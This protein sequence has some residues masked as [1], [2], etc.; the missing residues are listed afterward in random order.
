MCRIAVFPMQTI[1]SLVR[2]LRPGLCLRLWWRR[3]PVVGASSISSS[4]VIAPYFVTAPYIT[5]IFNTT[6]R[7]FSWMGFPCCGGGG[8]CL[9]CPI[10]SLG[11]HH[12]GAGSSREREQ[13]GLSA[14]MDTA[15]STPPQP[16]IIP[17]NPRLD[18]CVTPFKLMHTSLAPTCSVLRSHWG[19]NK[20]A[21]G[22]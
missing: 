4:F 17:F 14:A 10:R 22:G 19:G 1:V 8:C 2:L 7:F 18:V 13:G 11:W 6:Q 5:V 9:W 15:T 16:Q 3:R 21:R 20:T 12:V